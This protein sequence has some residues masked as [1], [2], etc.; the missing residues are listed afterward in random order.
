MSF[1]GCK[2]IDAVVDQRP[3]KQYLIHE[4]Y[5]EEPLPQS[6]KLTSEQTSCLKAIADKIK[7]TPLSQ[8]KTNKVETK[9][10]QMVIRV[11]RKKIKKHMRPK[12]AS[13]IG[14]SI[15]RASS[16]E[17]GFASEPVELPSIVERPKPKSRLTYKP[18]SHK[19]T[20]RREYSPETGIASVPVGEPTVDDILEDP[21]VYYDWKATKGGATR[22]KKSRARKTCRYL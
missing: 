10:M 7:K 3:F 12:T 17:T 21:W 16:A 6:S 5:P 9:I 2:S 11:G 4:F 13:E 22:R 19:T 15:A 20:I 14:Q 18:F 1:L 8:I